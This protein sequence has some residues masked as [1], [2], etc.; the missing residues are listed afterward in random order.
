VAVAEATETEVI[1][2]GARAEAKTRG[3]L[4]QTERDPAGR[5]RVARVAKAARA[6][7]VRAARVKAAKERAARVATCT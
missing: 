4:S 7:R 1:V 5:A 6:A 3:L 2:G